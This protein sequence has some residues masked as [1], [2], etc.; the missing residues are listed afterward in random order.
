MNVRTKVAAILVAGLT[1]GGLAIA[2]PP[3][4]FADGNGPCDRPGLVIDGTAGNDVLTGTPFNDV[5][6]GGGGDDVINGGGGSD[7]INGGAGNDVING[8]GCADRLNG[9]SGVDRISGG[10]GDDTLRGGAPFF[11]VVGDTGNGGPGTDN[12]AGFEPTA[13]N[14]P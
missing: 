2:A 8:Q 4:A 3:V 6:N 12:C 9:G 11:V 1:S 10:A 14:C 5:I 7:V 13:V